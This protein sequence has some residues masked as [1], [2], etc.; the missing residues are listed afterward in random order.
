M[1]RIEQLISDYLDGGLKPEEA[2][3]LADLLA[4]DP[5]ARDEFV[6]LYQVHRLLCAQNTKVSEAECAEQIIAALRDEAAE[7]AGEKQTGD[8]KTNLNP[9]TSGLSRSIREQ[10][11]RNREFWSHLFWPALAG[12][13]AVAV[14]LVVIGG[15]IFPHN[16]PLSAEITKTSPGVAVVRSG[17]TLAVYEG[18]QLRKGDMVETPTNGAAVIQYLGEITTLSLKPGTELVFDGTKHGKH[19]DLKTGEIVVVAGKQPT[20]APMILVTAQAQARVVGTRFQL[21]ARRFSTW[22]QVSEGGV[23]FKSNPDSNGQSPSPAG[24]KPEVN[25]VLVK[26]GEYAVA[27]DGI[28]LKTYEVTDQLNSA[29]PLP[30]KVGWFSYYGKPNWYIRPPMVQQTQPESI[31]R[32][33]QLPPTKGSILVAGTVSVDSTKG[34][35]TE[36]AGFGVGLSAGSDYFLAR[37]QRTDGQP[38]LEIVNLGKVPLYNGQPI[39][40]VSGDDMVS[41]AQVPLSASAWP[42]CK[43]AFELERG[44]AQAATVRA[45]AW[46]GTEEPKEWQISIPVNL[47]DMSEFFELRLMTEN[48][49]CTFKNTSAYLVE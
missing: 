29:H 39:L 37:I 20:N 3:E 8:S 27:A 30:I 21:A 32:T 15:F 31:T 40:D 33:F 16:A 5:A 10:A 49:A 22:L 28:P 7:V 2:R 19:L 18:F 35:L 9:L 12:A 41:L 13:V 25:E 46:T 45:K 11:K 4:Q 34:G 36:G 47:H 43:V 38:V 26:S 42:E 44:P 6:E 14:V 48:S 1:S 17:R 24:T 23:A